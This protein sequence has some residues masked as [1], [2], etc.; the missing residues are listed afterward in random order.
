M[1]TSTTLLFERVVIGFMGWAGCETCISQKTD[2]DQ[3]LV[4][5]LIDET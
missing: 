2:S 4:T 1:T 3:A 5:G